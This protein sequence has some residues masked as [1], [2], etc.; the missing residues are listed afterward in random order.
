M[1]V[2]AFRININDIREDGLHVVFPDLSACTEFEVDLPE[3]MI[4]TGSLAA[5][6]DFFREGRHIHLS[7]KIECILLLRCHRCLE[8]CIEKIN[9]T[10]YYLL[11]SGEDDGSA[12]LREISLGADDLDVWNYSHGH[13]ML[14]EIFREQLLLQVPVKVLCSPECRGIC[15]GCGRNLNEDECC[16]EAMDDGSP[17]A[18]LKALNAGKHDPGSN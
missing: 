15:P 1:T 4:L 12:G 2:P 17:F 8:E 7:G 18:I 13:I 5:E 10:F 9:R 14:D 3:G 11:Q 6:A 16:C